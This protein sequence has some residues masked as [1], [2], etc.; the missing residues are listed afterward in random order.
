MKTGKTINKII[1]VILAAFV[2]LSSI[3]FAAE[4]ADNNNYGNLENEKTENVGGNQGDGA[5]GDN[6]EESLENEKNV[7]EENSENE[8]HG[9]E[10]SLTPGANNAYVVF[11]K[12]IK[13]SKMTFEDGIAQGIKD[14]SDPNYSEEFT[15]DGITGRRVYKANYVNLTVDPS[16]Y[17]KDDHKFLFLI[18][19]YD[20][21][22]QVGYFHV[23]YGNEQGKY[24]S[25]SIA[26]R[27]IVPKWCTARLILDDVGFGGNI[28]GKYDI[29]ILTNLY[30]AFAKVE[31]VNLSA[32]ERSGGDVDLGTVNSIQQ[33]ALKQLGL[34]S[35]KDEKGNEAG[36][37]QKLTRGEAIKNLI[38][39]VGKKDEVTPKKCSF[40]DVKG[41]LAKYVAYAESMGIVKG[42]DDGRFMPDEP[43]T[44]RELLVFYM[45]FL[46]ID[47]PDIYENAFSVAKKEGL[48]L[49]SD[50]VL[51]ADKPL[52]RDNF[53]AIAYNAL[54]IRNK[55]S[56]SS[57]LEELLRE[58]KIT[59]EA[60]D[61]TGIAELAAYKYIIPQKIPKIKKTDPE[62]GREY[63]Y[64]NFNG[65]KSIRSYVNQQ[66]W[67]SD[68]TKFIIGNDKTDGMYEYDTETEMMT[69][70]DYASVGS[71]LTAVVNKND[72]IFYKNTNN[73]LWQMDWKTK[74]KKMIG[75]LPGGVTGGDGISVMDNGK[76]IGC[77]WLQKLDDEDYLNGVN[78]YRILARLNCET[79]EWY[80]ERSH[81]FN[82][83]PDAPSLG[84]P[85]I[86][87]VDENIMF[88]CHEGDSS[89][90]PDRLW[91]AN[92]ATGEDWNVFRQ[93]ERFD[94]KTGEGSGHE[95]WTADGKNLIF[96][97]YPMKT[98]VGKTG[99]C[100]VSLDGSEREYYNGDY[101]YWHCTVSDDGEWVA[102]DTNN[103]PRE[104]AL[105]STKTYKSTLLVKFRVGP[106]SQ[107][108]YQPHPTLSGN[109]KMIAWQMV[110][111]SDMLGTAWMDISD[112][113]GK[114]IRGGKEKLSETLS[115]VNYEDSE[116][117]VKK[118]QKNGAGCFEINPGNCMFVD[119]NDEIIKAPNANLKIKFGYLDEGRQPAVLKYTTSVE[120][121]TEYANCENA[122]VEIKRNGS[123][124]W[125]TAEVELKNISLMNSGKHI[126][127]FSVSGKHSK[128]Y[129]KDITVEI[130]K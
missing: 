69:F 95:L 45:R 103:S 94:G 53:V 70:L 88:F 83:I 27:G 26:K 117:E 24:S 28:G 107:H 11:D 84:H 59:G 2:C 55:K 115:Y 86:N 87:P 18:T 6:E 31:V 14:V 79:G 102:G 123:G 22:P 113:T 47:E 114:E 116:C 17:S 74:N 100:R 126:S 109:G 38:C 85:I 52:I 42:T 72:Q 127:D 57:P 68:A 71:S 104:I 16:Y 23:R 89:I 50:V 60:L 96:V 4:E 98:Q 49:D 9:D 110:D 51:F 66:E 119:V 33:E 99:I 8:N 112:I 130:N 34:Y 7:S 40:S 111:D 39:A 67:N 5:D 129:I 25:V 43:A 121:K 41:D 120:G 15:M 108:P 90:V 128:L 105:V 81:E 97:K 64:L 36:L 80:T 37:E 21:G 19:Y 48:L 101:N 1:A 106:S 61:S 3:S 125:K 35:G 10:I 46:N 32:I 91:V 93:A 78:R 75:K 29:R 77:K 73:E 76:Y 122:F 58:G 13:S 92:L 118:T 65:D 62:T 63:Y 124:K 30:N 56:G 82:D 12:K 20:F 54:R 44:P